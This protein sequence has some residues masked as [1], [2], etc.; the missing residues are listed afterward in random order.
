MVGGEG[1]IRDRT[2]LVC[3]PRRADKF[4]GIHC[5]GV[6]RLHNILGTSWKLTRIIP[7]RTFRVEKF[8]NQPRARAFD[9]HRLVVVG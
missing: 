1:E 3:H 5:G 7:F 4:L 8:S 6:H 2:K 9:A